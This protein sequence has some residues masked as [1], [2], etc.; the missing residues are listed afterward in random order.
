[1]Q[2]IHRPLPKFS[3]VVRL[4]PPQSVPLA[5]RRRQRTIAAA[6]LAAASTAAQIAIPPAGFSLDKAGHGEAQESQRALKKV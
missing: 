2:L 5:A 6:L 4:G 3:A 1:V